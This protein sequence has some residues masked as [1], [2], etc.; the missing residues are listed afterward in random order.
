M[1]PCSGAARI[2]APTALLE[3][4]VGGITWDLC[5]RSSV[6]WSFSILTNKYLL[7]SSLLLLAHGMGD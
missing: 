4:G 3:S 7:V 5:P 1:G 2:R 6:Q